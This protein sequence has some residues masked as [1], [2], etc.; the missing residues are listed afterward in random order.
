MLEADLAVTQRAIAT[1]GGRAPG[2]S[3]GDG[4]HRIAGQHEP[5]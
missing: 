4:A 1:L 3:P 2:A 5:A